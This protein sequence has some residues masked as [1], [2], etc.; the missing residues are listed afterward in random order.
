M[1][2][3]APE[4]K[5]FLDTRGDI[6]VYNGVFD[7]Y[8]RVKAMCIRF[9]I[10]DKYKIDYVFLEPKRASG[11]PSRALSGMAPD[12]HRQSCGAVRARALRGQ[13]FVSGRDQCMSLRRGTLLLLKKE[14]KS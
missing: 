10:L 4:L 5:T 12:L 8:L 3:N 14:K 11:L 9:E 6:F 13:P 7:D 1:E 2:W